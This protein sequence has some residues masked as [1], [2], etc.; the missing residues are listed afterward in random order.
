M[1]LAVALQTAAA[2]AAAQSETVS[3]VI[4]SGDTLDRLSRSFLVP[5]RRWRTL[6]KLAVIRDPKRLPIG[7]TRSSLR[8]SRATAARSGFRSTAG[9]LRPQRGSS[10]AKA[11]KS[12]PPA[13]ASPR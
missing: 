1:F 3:Y 5:E 7:R 10:S 2:S 11:P 9:R 4:R 12:L 6:L 8:V 13:T